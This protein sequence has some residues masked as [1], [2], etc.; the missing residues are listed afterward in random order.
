MHLS[1]F[2]TRFFQIAFRG[3][4]SFALVASSAP[5]TASEPLL[6][7]PSNE[8]TE[9]EALQVLNDSP[10]AHTIT[11]TTQD[12][13][14]DYEHPA[15]PGLFPEETAQ[16]A[17]SRSPQFPAESVKPDGAEY[18]VRLI[19]VKP[20]QAAAERLVSVD[21][22][23]APYRR[24]I[25]L[26]P[27]SKPT[28]MAEAWYNPA[29][30]ITVVLAL[31]RPG[32]GGASFLNYAFKDVETGVLFTAHYFCI[33]AGIR[34]ASGQIHA[35]MARMGQGND[36]NVSAIIMSFPSTVDGKSLISHRDEKL[37]FRLVLNQRVFE[38]KFIVNPTDLFD[39]TETLMRTPTRVDQPTP[40]TL[41]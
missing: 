11:T 19:S 35:V 25:G 27:G 36:N 40:P 21:E 32:P 24:G 5:L 28:N 15:Y 3:L 2:L 13:P 26:E 34:T 4:C 38:T 17:D 1:S 31:K 6:N 18:V 20:M 33:C 22:K 8:R 37:E 39:G 10:W 41:P 14:C 29:D 12:T 30:E 9:A 7:K 23:W 16:I